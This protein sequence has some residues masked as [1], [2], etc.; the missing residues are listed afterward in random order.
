MVERGIF[1]TT[2]WG[3]MFETNSQGRNI[4]EIQFVFGSG[5]LKGTPM[6]WAVFGDN[7][8][9]P[10]Q[11]MTLLGNGTHTILNDGL[12]NST[13]EPIK[14]KFNVSSFPWF[15]IAGSYTPPNS[16]NVPSPARTDSTDPQNQS[17]RSFGTSISDWGAG[18]IQNVNYAIRAVGTTAFIVGDVNGDGEVSLL[19]VAPFVNLITVNGFQI[20]ADI[21]GDGSVDLLDVAPFVDLLTSA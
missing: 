10:R 18:S 3:N 15:F 6:T 19:D 4:T 20:E 5:G 9:D 8:G 16:G 2:I 13:F 11:G 21:N 12:L 14:T 7:D 1:G 17:W